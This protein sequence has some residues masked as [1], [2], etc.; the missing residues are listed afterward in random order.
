MRAAC[1]TYRMAE[2]LINIGAYAPGSNPKI[3]KAIAMIDRINAFL[4]QS[5]GT[6]SSFEQTRKQL[7]EIAAPWEFLGDSQ[8][9]ESNDEVAV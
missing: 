7:M 6:R 3:D 2:D 5:S 8:L 1:S 4:C 9:R